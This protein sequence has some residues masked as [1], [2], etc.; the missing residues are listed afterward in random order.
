M[1]EVNISLIESTQKPYLSKSKDTS[2]ENDSG[3]NES[4]LLEYYLS[5]SV[6]VAGIYCTY[7]SKVQWI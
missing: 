7:V 4:H 3:K 6:E 1:S 5:K 2:L